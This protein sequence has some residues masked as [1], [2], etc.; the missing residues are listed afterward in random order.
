M[1]EKPLINLQQTQAQKGLKFQVWGVKKSK[2]SRGFSE[3]F[4]GVF[5][6]YFN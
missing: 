2:K 5:Q 6:K 1:L 3:G 4:F